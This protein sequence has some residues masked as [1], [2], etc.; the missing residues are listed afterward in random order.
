MLL[1]DCRWQMIIMG[2]WGEGTSLV[3]ISLS[4][5]GVN[6]FLYWALEM[7]FVFWTGSLSF[8]LK[9]CYIIA[10]VFCSLFWSLEGW[11]PLEAACCCWG[12]LVFTWNEG[13]CYPALPCADRCVWFAGTSPKATFLSWKPLLLPHGKHL[14]R[15]EFLQEHALLPVSSRSWECEGLTFQNGIYSAFCSDILWGWAKEAGMESGK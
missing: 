10:W 6:Q 9:T 13:F 15:V 11:P 12:G 2:W 7:H 1:A 3:E 8:S 4:Q 5:S 14:P